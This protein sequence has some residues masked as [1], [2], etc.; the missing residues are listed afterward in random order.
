MPNFTEKKL[1]HP[2]YCY[3]VF[4]ALFCNFDIISIKKK[5]TAS[6]IEIVY[7]IL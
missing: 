7:S 4:K 5:V 1:S 3:L 6:Q 2:N